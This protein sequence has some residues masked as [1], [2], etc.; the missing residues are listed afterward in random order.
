M[1]IASALDLSPVE[2]WKIEH[3]QTAPDLDLVIRMIDWL[4][5]P[6]GSTYAFFDGDE[7]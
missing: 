3:R 2:L 7:T 6:E 1:E 5:G 4:H